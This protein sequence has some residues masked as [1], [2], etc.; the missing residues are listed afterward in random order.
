LD[1]KRNLLAMK[2]P[3]RKIHYIPFG[4]DLE[5]FAP[6]NEYK[7][8]IREEFNIPPDCFLVGAV[9][10]IHPWKGHR[11]LVEAAE[12]ITRNEPRIRFLIVGDAAF[13]GHRSFQIELTRLVNKLNLQ[14]KIIFTGSR[15]DIPAI[16]NALDLFV[17]PS[18][19][20][21]FGL[22]F[23]E[24]QACGKPVIATRVGGIP[25]A[26]KDGETGILV[27]AGDGEALAAAIIHLMSE[28]ATR[29]RM[30]VEGRKRVEENFSVQSMVRNTEKLYEMILEGPQ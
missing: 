7:N 13:E 1:M 8:K 3:D 20:E 16:M 9:G 29:Q 30:G 21:P 23:L 25:E 12:I 19:K 2:V 27:K 5:K 15:K 11:Y 22:V 17:L 18:L 6:Q 4:I 10:R 28:P 26:I 24:A 14:D